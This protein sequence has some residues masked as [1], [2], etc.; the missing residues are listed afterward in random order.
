M[1]NQP[2]F[3]KLLVKPID[4]KETF[5]GIQMPDSPTGNKRGIVTK[6]GP[7]KRGFPMS[8]KEGAEVLYKTEDAWPVTIDEENYVIIIEEKVIMVIKD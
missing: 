1:E 4:K 3:D 6:A 5:G 7:G 8:V 2:L